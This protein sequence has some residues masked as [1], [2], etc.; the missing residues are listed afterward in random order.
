MKDGKESGLKQIFNQYYKYLLVTACH[1]VSDTEKAKDIVQDVFFDLWKNRE[2]LDINISL[3]AYL[4]RA[5]VNRSL[6]HIKQSGRFL[7]GDDGFDPSAK[8]KEATADQTLE[9]AD[10]KQIIQ[11]TIDRLPER[12]RT[13]F[14]L[15]RKEHLSHKEISE[16]LGISVKTIENQMTKALKSIRVAV[17]KYG[18]Q[19]ILL[20]SHFFENLF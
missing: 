12:C 8:A 19:L 3:K 1:Y 10:L 11:L 4:R 20:F 5:V 9:A 2:K 18:A 16:Q 13:V 14:L 6:N 15:S 17:T 7:L